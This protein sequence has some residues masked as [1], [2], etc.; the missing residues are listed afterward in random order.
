M[1]TIAVTPLHLTPGRYVRSHGRWYQLAATPVPN[2]RFVT[3]EG[4]S[5]DGAR[6]SWYVV[7]GELIE[8]AP[9]GETPDT[10]TPAAL[11]KRARALTE[12]R[13]QIDAQLRE[14]ARLLP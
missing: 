1:N 9:A 7:A 14:L 2:A 12:R 6:A 4:I 5:S 10:F 13:D 11:R 8:A 3:L